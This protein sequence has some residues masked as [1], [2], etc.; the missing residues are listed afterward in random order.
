[1]PQA[2]GSLGLALKAKQKFLLSGELRNNDLDCYGSGR[3]EVYG[4]EDG[5]HASPPEQPF[6]AVLAI[7]NKAWQRSEIHLPCQPL[8]NGLECRPTI[9][10]LREPS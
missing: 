3:A 1:M 10:S 9:L 7:E 5:A 2:S 8:Y 4:D 6:N